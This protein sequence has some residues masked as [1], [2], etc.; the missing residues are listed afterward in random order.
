MICRI[1]QCLGVPVYNAD[2]AARDLMTH[3]EQLKADIIKHFGKEAFVDGQLNRAFLSAKVFGNKDELARLNSLVHPAVHRDYERWVN[4][5][6]ESPYTIKEAA[7]IFEAGTNR[8]LDKVIVVSAPERLR[9]TRVLAR[10]PHRSERDVKQIM[11][12]QM[13]ES[14]KRQKADFIINNDE[15]ELVIPQVLE[16]HRRLTA[17][18]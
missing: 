3:D 17:D 9:I 12:D 16:L 11:L 15:S 6:R 5:H 4:N 7:L 2:Q 18:K 1:F 10:D 8:S 13:P 14:E